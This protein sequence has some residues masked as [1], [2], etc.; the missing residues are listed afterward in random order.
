[1]NLRTAIVF[2]ACHMVLIWAQD[3]TTS[4]RDSLGEIVMDHQARYGS[5]L[6]K[7]SISVEEVSESLCD[8]PECTTALNALPAS[9]GI[10]NC[11]LDGVNLHLVALEL[12]NRCGLS[13]TPTSLSTSASTVIRP[14]LV[15]GWVLTAVVLIFSVPEYQI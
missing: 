7:C 12:R 2:T 15:L 13:N 4:Q 10:P 1:M 9:A 14:S 6:D 3:C 8:N 11:V 5:I